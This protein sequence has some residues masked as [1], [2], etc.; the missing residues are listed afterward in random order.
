MKRAKL[1]IDVYS[2]VTIQWAIYVQRTRREYLT[3]SLSAWGPRPQ[4]LVGPY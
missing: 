3:S 4:A 2:R 1:A